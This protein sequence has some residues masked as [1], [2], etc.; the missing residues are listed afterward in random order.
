MDHFLVALMKEGTVFERLQ[1][2]VLPSA[3]E[4]RNRLGLRLVESAARVR[5]K[6]VS[7]LTH[8]EYDLSNKN[9]R[10]LEVLKPRQ[11]V[12]MLMLV[13]NKI[14]KHITSYK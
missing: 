2:L 12:V 9:R 3:G 1:F 11:Q 8:G 14:G 6:M 7:S 13:C 4:E 10:P 5:E